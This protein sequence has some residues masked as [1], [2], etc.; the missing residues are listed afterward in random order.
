MRQRL[1]QIA[2]WVCLI[3]ILS[4][5]LTPQGMKIARGTSDKLHHTAAFF[6][7]SFLGD[8]AFDRP[9]FHMA[10][11]LLGFG[12]IIELVQFTLPYRSFSLADMAANIGGIMVYAGLKK[13]LESLRGK[14]QV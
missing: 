3:S 12:M 1:Y 9:F 8:R 4:L 14:S 6:L 5:A 13:I 10:L 2:F 7:L 11:Y